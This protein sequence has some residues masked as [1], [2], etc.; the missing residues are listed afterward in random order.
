VIKRTPEKKDKQNME[1]H[2]YV[3]FERFMITP[4]EQSNNQPEIISKPLVPKTLLEKEKHSSEK[5]K[6]PS[7]KN[8]SN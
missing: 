7:K 3:A 6:M 8:V 1:Y 2:N 5:K 4:N